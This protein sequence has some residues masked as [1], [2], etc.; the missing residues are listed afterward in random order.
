MR[1]AGG[2]ANLAVPFDR[3]RT[4]RAE[5]LQ[6]TGDH[7][8][9]LDIVMR[10]RLGAFRAGAPPGQGGTMI[11]FGHVIEGAD[12]NLDRNALGRAFRTMPALFEIDLR[13][14]DLGPGSHYLKDS[15]L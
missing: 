12:Q 6:R 8:D 7:I 4:V 10:D 11:L 3:R 14:I 9:L 1:D 2:P 5:P 13:E 15:Q